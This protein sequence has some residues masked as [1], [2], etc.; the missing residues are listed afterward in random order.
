MN[1]YTSSQNAEY[2]QQP[3]LAHHKYSLPSSACLFIGN[4]TVASAHAFMTIQLFYG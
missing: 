3:S 1:G 4:I 2:N